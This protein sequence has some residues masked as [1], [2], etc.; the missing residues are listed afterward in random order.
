MAAAVER[1]DAAT[2]RRM[3]GGGHAPLL[4]CDECGKEITKPGTGRIAWRAGEN[5]TYLTAV[6]LHEGC[7][8]AH[9]ESVPGRLRIDPLE[10]YLDSLRR[11]V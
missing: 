9:G 4:R 10:N 2:V 6:F 7:V 3:S 5:A 8:E 11:F 1:L